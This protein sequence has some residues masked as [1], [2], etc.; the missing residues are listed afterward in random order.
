M[1]D[2]DL[3]EEGEWGE[4]KDSAEKKVDEPLLV[5]PAAPQL[6]QHVVELQRHRGQTQGGFR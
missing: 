6:L 4:E 3:V 1:K 5:P 2:E